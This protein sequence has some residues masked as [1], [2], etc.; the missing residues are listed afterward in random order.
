MVTTL[1][2]ALP[3][4]YDAMSSLSA[5]AQAINVTS[6]NENNT[7][8]PLITKDQSGNVHYDNSLTINPNNTKALSDK[9][10]ALLKQKKFNEA[11]GMFDKALAINPN[12][13]KA[14][15]DKGEALLKLKN[16]N[17][18]ITSF[19]K[20]LAINPNNAGVLKDKQKALDELSRVK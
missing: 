7:R 17:E 19:D 12:N 14:L 15:S 9:G 3:L 20:A 11:I 6:S 10:E 8:P 13:T 18:A 1:L 4:V 2:I 16:F 5:S